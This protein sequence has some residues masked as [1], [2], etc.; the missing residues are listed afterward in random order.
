MSLSSLQ[1]KIDQGFLST[2]A[3]KEFSHED[4]EALIFLANE[5]CTLEVISRRLNC[6]K[7][8]V[9]IRAKVFNI[10]LEAEIVDF[11][12]AADKYISRKKY[13][14]AEEDDVILK[15][16]I[17]GW[18][19]FRIAEELGWSTD[20]AKE[21]G[22][23]LNA[24]R[25]AEEFNRLNPKI[26]EQTLVNERKLANP[27]NRRLFTLPAGHPTMWDIIANGMQNPFNTRL[28]EEFVPKPKRIKNP[29]TAVK[30]HLCFD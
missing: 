17:L 12:S 2:M 26:V 22:Y 9:K 19:W 5:G 7:E 14:T 13:S 21:R 28:F 30:L 25:K 16:C 29:K 11:E 15:G 20:R 18:S 4:D 3:K 27:D 23:R 24:H 6:S 10:S 8:E 1:P